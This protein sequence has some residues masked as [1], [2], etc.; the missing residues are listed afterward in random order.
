[1]RP[2]ALLVVALAV[3]PCRAGDAIVVLLSAKSTTGTAAVSLGQVAKL[4][5][6]EEKARRKLAA[7]DLAERSRKDAPVTVTRRQV[8]LRLRLAGYGEDAVLVGGADSVVVGFAKK[9]ASIDDAIAAARKAL[10]ERFDNAADWKAEVAIA[11]SA[12]LPEVGDADRVEFAAAPHAAAVKPGRNQMDVTV[13]VNGET[14]LAFPIQ[15]DV[16][17]SKPETALV[18]AR[19]PVTLVVRAG[20]LTVEAAGEALQDGREGETVQV[21]NATTKKT[22]RGRVVAAD[23]VEIEP[24]GAP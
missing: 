23:R 5:G 9:A 19:R 18:I 13:K 21:R 12:K 4:H 3:A 24:G 15:F 7:L 8:E 10:L 17:S 2:F 14:K 20:G 1:M 11:P 6:G 16:K 22:L